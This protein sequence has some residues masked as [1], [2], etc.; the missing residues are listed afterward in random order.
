MANTKSQMA[1]A[2]KARD[3]AIRGLLKTMYDAFSYS[4]RTMGTI[5]KVKEEGWLLAQKGFECALFIHHYA[6]T[7]NFGMYLSHN[8]FQNPLADFFCYKCAVL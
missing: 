8:L 1:N 5:S 4:T 2:Q 7:T 6:R 3:K